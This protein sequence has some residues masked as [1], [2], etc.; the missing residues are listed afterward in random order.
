M[1]DMD[2]M[3]LLLPT[4]LKKLPKS[5]ILQ[6]AKGLGSTKFEEYGNRSKRQKMGE[7]E[8]L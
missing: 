3:T 8:K 6:I 4:I 2:G 7:G 5:W 1:L